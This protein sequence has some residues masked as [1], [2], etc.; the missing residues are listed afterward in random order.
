MQTG[1]LKMNFELADMNA[2][3][4]EVCSVW[5]P[6]FEAKTVEL[7]IVP[8]FGLQPM[9]FDALKVQHGIRQLHLV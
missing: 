5:K 2:A 1:K 9:V 4:A 3:L 8:S 7:K 6:Q